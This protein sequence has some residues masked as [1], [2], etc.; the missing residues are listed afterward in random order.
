MMELALMPLTS[1]TTTANRAGSRQPP[2][3]SATMVRP[4]M[5]GRPAQGSRITEMRP[6]Y[7]R[8]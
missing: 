6:A 8:K 3:R 1:A 5:N 4:S 7:C 2:R